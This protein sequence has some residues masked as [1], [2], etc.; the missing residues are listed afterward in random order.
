MKRL[1]NKL[2][3]VY[4][5][6][7]EIIYSNKP[8]LVTTVLGSCLSIIMFSRKNNYSAISHCQLP[9]SGRSKKN[10]SNCLEPYKYVDC[11]VEKMLE[12]F[13]KLNISKEE[14][15]VKIFGG[16]DVIGTN[17]KNGNSVTIGQQNILEALKSLKK[18]K[19]IIT[20]ADTGGN[21]GRK[22]IFVTNSG[23]IYLNR[24]KSNEKN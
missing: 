19:L 5:N 3:V 7:G 15:E 18:H 9:A 14:I 13:E 2:P 12:T 16:A 4:L 20:A 21:V 6:P 11:T 22:I 1:M 17:Q 8:M 10:N 24:L 23:E